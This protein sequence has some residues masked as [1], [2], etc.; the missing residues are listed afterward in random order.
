MAAEK[1]YPLPLTLAQ[2]YVLKEQ[3]SAAAEPGQRDEAEQ[4][5]L[6]LVEETYARAASSERRRGHLADR[7]EGEV[8]QRKAGSAR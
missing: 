3:L 7:R 8:P 1:T 5:L 4:A 6:A 2:L